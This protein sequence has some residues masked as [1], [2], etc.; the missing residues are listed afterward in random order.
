M[1]SPT[2]DSTENQENDAALRAV[3]QDMRALV[4]NTRM[5]LASLRA[6]HQ[7]FCAL[8]PFGAMS[9]IPAKRHSYPPEIVPAFLE[10][11]DPL[12]SPLTAYTHHTGCR[13]E[14]VFLPRQKPNSAMP[15][16]ACVVGLLAGG[17]LAAAVVGVLCLHLKR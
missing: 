2:N 7:V 17:F 8:N 1:T 6:M 3:V 11:C 12:R 14:D 15:R 9:V 13:V 16:F 5:Q 4:I 10:A